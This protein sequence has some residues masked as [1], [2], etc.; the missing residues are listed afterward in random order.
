MFDERELEEMRKAMMS[1]RAEQE[2]I[3]E[4]IR[5][6]AVL[7]PVGFKGGV[8]ADIIEDLLAV[9]SILEGVEKKFISYVDS[10]EKVDTFG[11]LQ[12]TLF[13]DA[14]KD[15]VHD[16]VKLTVIN[17]QVTAEFMQ[18]MCDEAECDPVHLATR[19]MMNSIMER[20]LGSCP[21]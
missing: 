19:I 18:E 16:V 13:K 1:E 9:S 21:E 6:T 17:K 8:H 11:M 20:I 5:K 2:S 14:L 4:S 7:E 3:T 10:P 15:C 12:A